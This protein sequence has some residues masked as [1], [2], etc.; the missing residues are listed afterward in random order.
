M[1]DP[2][3]AFVPNGTMSRQDIALGSLAGLSLAVK[4]LF[5]VAGQVAGRGNPDWARTHA[6]AETDAPA[7]KA[8]MDAG[9]TCVG[10][11]VLDEFAYSLSG[12]NPHHGTPTNPNAPG[13]LT[14]GSSCGSAAAVAGGVADIALGTDTGGSI[15]VPASYC[16]L[17][18]LRPTHG[19]ISLEGV[20]P[21][22]PRFD[23]VGWFA[24][25]AEV[26]KA[27]GDVLLP[28]SS[29]GVPEAPTRLVL[30]GDA[31]DLAESDAGRALEGVVARMG[32]RFEGGQAVHLADESTGPLSA[33]SDA[34]RLL[35]AQQAHEVLGDWIAGTQPHLGPEMTD[36]W[37]Y[38]RRVAGEDSRAAEA[39]LAAVAARLEALTAEGG[40]VA[41]PSAPGAAPL[42]DSDDTA[43]AE[44]RRRTLAL[45][46]PASLAG[47]PQIALPL[48][49][50]AG[51]PLGL[52][53]IGPRGSDRM[54]LDF[55]VEL[56]AQA[57]RDPGTRFD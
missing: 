13:R 1:Q 8:C 19:A 34:F 28:P 9:A 31:F 40:I 6:P 4:D 22:A 24:R 41:L 26:L 38:A 16:G 44:H 21:L 53:L 11:T 30:A 46:V 48:A 25:D 54:L 7:V 49:T 5:D 29:P 20:G 42:I 12:R 56:D 2:L 36:R 23:T 43:L 15:R 3:G 57:A 55:A 35:Q 39:T 10:R 33:W 47:L 17:Y 32:Q 50:T 45:T 52:G 18:G 14:G 37:N 51:L 27:V